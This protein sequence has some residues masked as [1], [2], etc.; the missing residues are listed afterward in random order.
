MA[1]HAANR[2][3]IADNAE[4]SVAFVDDEEMRR[5][6]LEYRGIDCTTDVLSFAFGEGTQVD[7][8]LDAPIILGDIII[9]IERAEAQ[10]REY[11]HSL[12]RELAFLLM[13]GLLHIVGYD[14]DEENE[15]DMKE[16][17]EALIRDLGF[18]R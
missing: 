13:H 18:A 16:L 11:G 14:H 4:L 7:M 5:L 17:N 2:L 12:E 6:N 10:A 15:G 1:D 9:S 3:S 8:P